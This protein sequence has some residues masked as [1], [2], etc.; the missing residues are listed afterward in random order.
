MVPKHPLINKY[1]VLE[2]PLLPPVLRFCS[3]SRSEGSGSLSEAHPTELAG[4]TAGKG[5]TGSPARTALLQSLRAGQGSVHPGP[6][7]FC[8]RADPAAGLATQGPARPGHGGAA[9]NHP[10]GTSMGRRESHGGSAASA[11]RA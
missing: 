3:K 8:I 1:K 10:Q 7:A 6:R 2:L 5:L 11:V 9:Q 4:H